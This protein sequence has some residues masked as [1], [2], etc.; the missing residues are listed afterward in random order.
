V[1]RARNFITIKGKFSP[2]P[3]RKERAVDEQLFLWEEL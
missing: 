1:K 2:F 3:S